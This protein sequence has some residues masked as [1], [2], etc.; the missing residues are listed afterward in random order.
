MTSSPRINADQHGLAMSKLSTSIEEISGLVSFWAALFFLFIAGEMAFYVHNAG[1]W[2]PVV[3]IGIWGLAL[4]VASR[5]AGQRVVLFRI[6]D[7]NSRDWYGCVSD[8]S[9]LT[10]YKN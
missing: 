7:G 9:P 6:V 1:E 4:L 3:V 2:I 8:I 10:R 5:R